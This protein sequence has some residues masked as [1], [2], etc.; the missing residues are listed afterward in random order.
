MTNQE[1]FVEVFG[2]EYKRQCS[3][4]SWWEQEYNRHKPE[5]EYEKFAFWVANEIF[6]ELWDIN[7]QAFVELACRRLVKLGIVSI[8]NGLYAFNKGDEDED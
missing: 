3:T 7:Y 8:E 6:D 2:T 4:K 1:K 5:N